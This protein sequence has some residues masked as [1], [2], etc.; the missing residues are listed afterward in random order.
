MASLEFNKDYSRAYAT[1][2]T[3]EIDK[4]GKRKRKRFTIYNYENLKKNAFIT[5][6]K[7]KAEMEEARLK[8]LG[9]F[10]AF[11]K[12]GVFA[13]YYFFEDYADKKYKL[14][15]ATNYKRD[16]NDYILPSFASVELGK[17]RVIDMQTWANDLQKDTSYSIAIR[18]LNAFKSIMK[19]AYRLELI[20]SNPG[21]KVMI[22]NDKEAKKRMPFT[23]KDIELLIPKINSLKSKGLQVGF[24]LGIYTGLRIGE[25]LGL[26]W[27]D[28]DFET[29]S[30]KV[31]RQ[32]GTN[33]GGW[34]TM[35]PKSRN[36]KRTVYFPSQ[37]NEMLQDWKKEQEKERK[38][39]GFKILDDKDYGK[40]DLVVTG[41]KGNSINRELFNYYLGKWAIEINEEQQKAAE[42]TGE[43]PY[44]FE[45]KSFH[46]F[47]H[48]YTSLLVESAVPI[49]AVRDLLGH[50]DA[51]T[52][53]Q[54]YADSL[55]SEETRRKIDEAYK[56]ITDL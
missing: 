14:T 16:Y 5:Y 15:T 4:N 42:I 43:K 9:T 10:N 47:R 29:S 55:D 22:Y 41:E 37:L 39:R 7:N 36:A 50:G 3:N 25:I 52:T 2:Y 12:L 18:A 28:I 1:A 35:E 31:R 51:A 26:T 6:A 20:D 30:L 56:N 13:K 49:T 32:R 33:T 27:S 48:F 54:V 40:L 24:Y 19:E 34:R 38:E 21:D 44:Y 17:I 46:S 23:K 8:E 53:F 45:Y 11:T